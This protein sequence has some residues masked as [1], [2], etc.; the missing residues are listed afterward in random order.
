M[1]TVTGKVVSLP[2]TDEQR[3]ARLGISESAELLY[4]YA[5]QIK[6]AGH[7]TVALICLR[8]AIGMC[9]E[10][11][12]LW[13]GYGAALWDIGDYAAASDALDH[14]REL[15]DDSAIHHSNR[16][17]LEA[18]MMEWQRADESFTEAFKRDPAS[19]HTRW[20]VAHANLERG[21]WAAGLSNYEVRYQYR[22]EKLYPKMP[23][24]MWVGEDLSGKTI[25]VQGEQGAGD[26]ILFSRYIHWLKMR[27]PDAKI[28]FAPGDELAALFSKFFSE[29]ICEYVPDNTGW[30][31]AD[32]GAFLASLPLRHGTDPSNVYPD[33]GLIRKAALPLRFKAP[34]PRTPALKVG[35]AWT[36]NPTMSR[37]AERTIPLPMLLELEDN[38]EVQL[39]NLQF[40]P[41]RNDIAAM[42]AD[43][44]VQDLVPLIGVRGF[45]GTA[46]AMLDLDLVI[47]ACTSVAHLAGA[48]G[49]PCW[50][51]LCQD[52]YWVWLRS[53]EVTPWYPSIR[54]VRQDSP[55]DWGPVIDRVKA[56]LAVY[57]ARHLDQRLEKTA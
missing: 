15:G 48:L 12:T 53:G 41:P 45:L 8:R 54:L 13:T 26:R 34:P 1:A 56:D 30:P 9:P 19:L 17:L 38:P 2:E 10:C 33:P 36:G 32:Y 14:A 6:R 40:G 28:K 29:G 11:A 7:F 42:G 4:N 31:S 50:V 16:G 44:M 46:A 35:I 57:A 27:W 25:Y 24:P 5:A 23:F 51:L 39:Y 37:N 47:T 55:G 20:N 22:G 43:Q 21:D 49:I 18:S 3:R 52:P